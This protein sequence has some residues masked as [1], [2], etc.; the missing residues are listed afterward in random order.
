MKPAAVLEGAGDTRCVRVPMQASNVLYYQ[1]TI[2]HSTN[3]SALIGAP[4]ASSACSGSDFWG[5]FFFFFF[6]YSQQPC[7]RDVSHQGKIN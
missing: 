7:Q 1:I 6:F 5:T 4:S 3:S 2:S